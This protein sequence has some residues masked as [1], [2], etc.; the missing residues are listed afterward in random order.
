M[1]KNSYLRE[2][3]DRRVASAVSNEL[4]SQIVSFAQTKDI[5]LSVAMR[6]LI[7]LGL[8]QFNKEVSDGMAI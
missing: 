8:E 4:H 5:N 7:Q 6:E 1:P 2:T 3:L